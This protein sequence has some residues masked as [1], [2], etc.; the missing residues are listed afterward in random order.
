MGLGGRGCHGGVLDFGTQV[1]EQ[2][3]FKNTIE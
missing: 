3:R 1:Q 2:T